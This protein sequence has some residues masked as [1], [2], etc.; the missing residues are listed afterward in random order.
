MNK[1][2]QDYF[3][4]RPLFRILS[5][6]IKLTGNTIIRTQRLW[7]MILLGGM[8]VAPLAHPTLA[9][10]TTYGGDSYGECEYQRDCP[11][12]TEPT[13]PSTSNPSGES[14]GDNPQTY[15]PPPAPKNP[16]FEIVPAGITE[17]QVIRSKQV[18]L[19]VSVHT[20]E[21][22]ASVPYT[23]DFGWVRFYVNDRLIGTDYTPN[24]DGLYTIIWDVLKNPGSLVTMVAYDQ[25]G[26]PVARKDLTVIL[27]L[28][29]DLDTATPAPITDENRP[30]SWI[31]EALVT[32]LRSIPPVVV[33][34]F[35]YWLFLALFVLAIGYLYQTGREAIATERMRKLLKRQQL[36]AE[37]KDNFIA[38]GSHYLHTPLTVMRNGADT[39]VAIKEAP[40]TVTAPLITALSALKDRIDLVLGKVESNEILK[41]I[42]QPD[43]IQMSG[44]I[45]TNPAY[46]VPVAVA[47]SIIVVMNTLLSLVGKWDFSIRNFGTQLIVGAI[48]IGFLFIAI[49]SYH[50]RK[51]EKRKLDQL[52]EYE[53][54]IDAARTGFIDESTA[55]LREGLAG[56]ETAKASL[57]QSA[58]A[59]FVTDGYNRFAEIL[60]R[61]DLLKQL[62]AG[63]D[64]GAKETIQLQDVFDTI[65]AEYQP[66]ILAKN[67]TIHADA[68]GIRTIGSPALL[69]YV[70]R[71]V[72]DN[73]V[74]FTPDG[75]TITIGA[76]RSSGQ[77][78]VAVSDNGSGIPADK[79]PTLF[80][81]FSRAG[82]ALTFDYEGL[83]FSLFLDRI[84]MDYLEGDIRV[85]SQEQQGT[86]V[87]VRA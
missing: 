77:V 65:V 80:K 28:P 76:N 9:S 69:T 10:A 82:S 13:S 78:E 86:L 19:G 44:S 57:P 27:D 60:S 37:E 45:L 40:E 83:G 39:M 64:Y 23:G 50:L 11:D 21:E 79:L 34:T 68:K 18:T 14:S 6:R 1:I 43:P 61:F 63:A 26:E 71:T 16:Q 48:V 53:H 62:R 3:L 52:V 81:P 4:T 35:P 32:T 31:P 70:I 54:A 15:A 74:K 36:I 24:E 46:W 2:N 30:P 42:K 66:T 7:A 20:L 55:A 17:G 58:T 87:T 72:I 73:A 5:V 56:V 29:K 25:N 22:A 12:S 33:Y 59:N 38:L 8:L 51:A 85:Q 75:G 84:I 49:R 41:D 47:A 67:L